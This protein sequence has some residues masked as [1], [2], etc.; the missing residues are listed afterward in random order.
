MSP[1]RRQA[2]QA[3]MEYVVI[4]GVIVLALYVADFG[5]GKNAAQLLV[6]TI[7]MVFRNFTYYLSLP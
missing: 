4:A 6:D 7:R 3:A 5:G 2:G 1:R